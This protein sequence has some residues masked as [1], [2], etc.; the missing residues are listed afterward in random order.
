M[1]T[2]FPKS[3]MKSPALTAWTQDYDFDDFFEAYGV[4]KSQTYNT[5]KRA[6]ED[7]KTI[8]YKVIVSIILNCLSKTPFSED[9]ILSEFIEQASY[10]DDYIGDLSP[11]EQQ[12]KNIDYLYNVMN[13][14]ITARKIGLSSPITIYRG[15]NYTR[16]EKLF[17]LPLTSS[18]STLE[19]INEGEIITIPTFLSTSVVRNSALRFASR[20][21]FF[22]EIFIPEDKLSV[23][24]Y[25]YLGDEVD[26]DSDKLKESE[27]LLNIG[28][29]LKYINSEVTENT[30]I[31]PLLNGKTKLDT[32]NCVIQRFEFVG[33]SDKVNL[34][35]LDECLLLN[36]NKKRRLE[37]EYGQLRKKSKKKKTKKKKAK[38]R[39]RKKKS[40]K[41]KS[42]KRSKKKRV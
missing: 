9:D 23:F 31:T 37:G 8:N 24:K 15:F 12:I 32:I 13:K 21:S 36:L 38:K 42:K 27:I 25:V 39:S 1:T 2:K 19:N 6:R 28:T 41:K 29:Q 10:E 26:L 17:K 5:R 22:W 11:I 30:V 14:W 3:P 18:G 35:Y 16:Y 33:Y 7:A 34:S 4:Y 40:K 20:N